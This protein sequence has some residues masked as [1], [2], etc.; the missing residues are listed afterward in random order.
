VCKHEDVMNFYADQAKERMAEFLTV[1]RNLQ[2]QHRFLSPA[3]V[4]LLQPL[5]E[6][7]A[8]DLQD[9]MIHKHPL[10]YFGPRRS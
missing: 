9:V 3:G 1:T 4:R 6:L 5:L 8:N 7:R 2:L 10:D